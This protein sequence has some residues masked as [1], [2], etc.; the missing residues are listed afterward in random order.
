[1]RRETLDTWCERGIL[2]LVLVVLVWGPLAMGAVRPSEFLVIQGATMGVLLLWGARLW[3]SPRP[4]VL[5]PPICWVVAAFVGYA[6]IRYHYAEVE[7][8]ARQELIR[9]LIYAFLFFALLNNL[10]RQ[11]SLQVISSTLITLAM[12][13]AAYAVYQFLT[14]SDW[15]WRYR[16]GFDYGGSGTYVSRNHLGGFLEMLLPL[17]LAYTLVS[18]FKPVSKVLTGYASLVILAGIVATVSRGTYLSTAVAL[19]L[20]FGV[21]LFQRSHRLPAFLLLVV[22]LAAGAYLLP[23][24]ISV[25]LRF[26]QYLTEPGPDPRAEDGKRSVFWD[27]EDARVILWQSAL[28]VWEQNI[29]WGVGPAHYDVRFPAYRPLAMQLHPYFAHNDYLQFLA[30]WGLVGAGLGAAA[31]VLLGWGVVGSWRYVRGAT[32]DLGHPRNSSKFAF[33][34]GAVMGLV[35]ILVHSVVDFN[36]H[37]PANAILAVTLAALLSSCLRFASERH[38]QSLK[39]WGKALGS[40]LVLAGT[41]Y[42]GQQGWRNAREYAW[43][44]R[45]DRAPLFTMAQV[46]CLKRA[47]AAEP[48]NAETAYAIGEIYRVKSAEGGDDYQ[49]LAVQALEWF[50]RSLELNPWNAY[51]HLRYGWCLDWL[52]RFAES[53]PFF[54]RAAQL[55]PNGFEVAANT[56]L[57][58]AQAGNY[59]AARTWFERSLRLERKSNPIASS[60]LPIVTSRLLEAATNEFSAG[61]RSA[62]Q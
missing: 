53:P 52:G 1:M 44:Q 62:S 34:L 30:E 27:P 39:W 29:W 22:V 51:G 10:H 8:L 6:L 4:Q 28:R 21:L 15:V 59:A 55:D 11:E 3:L 33:V 38:W 25:R 41:V 12:V 46:D 17:G 36:L 13:I 9:L 61:L 35:A 60:Y 2:G 58:Y 32:S 19:G 48:M 24:N 49:E 47:F 20:F 16:V 57:H 43:L 54:A 45:A 50:K 56:G 42:L 26:Q 37:I 7:Y 40:V 23:R 31:L 18:R 5:W 14:R